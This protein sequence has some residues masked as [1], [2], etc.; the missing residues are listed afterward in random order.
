MD[1]S[2]SHPLSAQV[3][4]KTQAPPPP[5]KPA[6]GTSLPGYAIAGFAVAGFAGAALVRENRRVCFFFFFPLSSQISNSY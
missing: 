3:A 4:G 6:Q 5:T 2:L 1:L